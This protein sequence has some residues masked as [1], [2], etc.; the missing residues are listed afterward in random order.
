MFGYV[1]PCR[2]ELKMRECGE[3]RSYYCGLCKELKREY[4]F[5]SRM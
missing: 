4:G 2:P 3:Y 1:M 5:T